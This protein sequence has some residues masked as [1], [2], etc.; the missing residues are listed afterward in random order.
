MKPK[1]LLNYMRLL[2][3]SLALIP[4]M[5]MA[6][7]PVI[8]GVVD[9][10]GYGPRVAPGSLASLFGTDLASRRGLGVRGFR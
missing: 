9:S 8:Q 3:L 7:A 4:G 1:R 10:A 2:K 6:A 5:A